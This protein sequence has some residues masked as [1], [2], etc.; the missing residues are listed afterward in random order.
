MRI[1]ITPPIEWVHIP[2]GGLRTPAVPEKTLGAFLE[3]RHA[4]DDEPTNKSIVMPDP[5][6]SLE[7]GLRFARMPFAPLRFR[8]GAQDVAR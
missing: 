7:R 1:G 4:G 5:D 3:L 6:S 8:T 2:S